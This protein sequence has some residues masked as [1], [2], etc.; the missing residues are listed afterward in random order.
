M[1]D[2]WIVVIPTVPSFVPSLDIAKQVEAAVRRAVRSCDELTVETHDV[3]V[4]YDAGSNWEGVRCPVCGVELDDEIWSEAMS[5]AHETGDL[6]LDMPCCDARTNLND[7]AYGWACGFARFAVSARNPESSLSDET[8]AD[9]ASLLG[10][11]IRLVQRH[12]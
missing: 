8:A 7:L 2:N 9:I 4:F 11:P 5:V 3:P 12:L 10:A 1:S 6:S